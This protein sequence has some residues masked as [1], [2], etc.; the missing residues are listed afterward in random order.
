MPTAGPSMAQI[1]GLRHSTSGHQR[2]RSSA[3]PRRPR[4]SPGTVARSARSVPAQNAPGTPVTTTTDVDS[5]ALATETASRKSNSI[6][7]VIALRLAGRSMVIVPTF[8]S[9]VYRMNSASNAAMG[10]R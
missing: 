3:L 5:S 9:V 4:V 1:V 2:S 10:R 7:Y 6:A 8:P